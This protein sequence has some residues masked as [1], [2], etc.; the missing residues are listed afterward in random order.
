MA[1]LTIGIFLASLALYL[2]GFL[3]WG[4]SPLPYSAW[5]HTADDASAGQALREHFPEN[6]TYYVPGF[7]NDA[8][9]RGK[10]YEAGPVG[11][12]HITASDGRPEL[13]TGIMLRGFFVNVLFVALLA[14]LMRNL[15]G[16]SSAGFGAKLGFAAFVGV[17]ASVLIDL[18]EVAWWGLSL[19]WKVR[20]AAYNVSAW[21]VAGAALAPFIGPRNSSS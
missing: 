11:F 9:T 20:M 15:F 17:T 14:F 21:L 5:K 16:N 7:Q 13:D 10:L 12:V 3:Y 1:R 2:W 6:G 19:D 18:G 8:D 4:M